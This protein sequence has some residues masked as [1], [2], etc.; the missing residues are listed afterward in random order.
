M[1]VKSAMKSGLAT[2]TAISSL[3]R[4]SA[5]APL[6]NNDIFLF[7]ANHRCCFACV[8][9]QNE[10]IELHEKRHGRRIDAGERERKREARSV[11]KSSKVAQK[12]RGLKAKLLNQKRY[13][14]K[15]EMKKT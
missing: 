13:K 8:Q 10:H 9:P 2:L 11:H 14:E 4:A 5:V 1:S 6:R 3:R 12:T 7:L 15:V